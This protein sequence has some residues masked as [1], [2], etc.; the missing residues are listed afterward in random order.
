M[1]W[2]SL[3]SWPD[4]G[5]A[6]W[7]QVALGAFVVVCEFAGNPVTCAVS[8]GAGRGQAPGSP[9][10]VA[11]P[12]AVVHLEASFDLSTIGV[13]RGC[14]RPG[15]GFGAAVRNLHGVRAEVGLLVGPGLEAGA[16]RLAV[17]AGWSAFLEDP[18]YPGLLTDAMLSERSR[19]RTT[20]VFEP[21]RLVW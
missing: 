20:K 7:V 14:P 21:S 19:A 6:W 18:G 4:S 2:L 12:V 1:A 16:L 8:T 17:V 11:A 13:T 10:I 5:G 3:A 15:S 9:L